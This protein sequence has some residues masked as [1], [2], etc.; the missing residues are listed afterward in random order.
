MNIKPLDIIWN[1]LQPHTPNRFRFSCTVVQFEQDLINDVEQT[2]KNQTFLYARPDYLTELRKVPKWSISR[3]C[4]LH[5]VPKFYAW[6]MF[7]SLWNSYVME[8]FKTLKN[9]F[10]F[11]YHLINCSMYTIKINLWCMRF[12]PECS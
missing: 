3:I 10:Y 12:S 4:I 9:T 5:N 2:Q 8:N 7:R 6:K 1:L 11:F